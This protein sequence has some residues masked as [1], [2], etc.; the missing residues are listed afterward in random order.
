VVETMVG[1]GG[2][3]RMAERVDDV[4]ER[5]VSVGSKVD[6]LASTAEERFAE[7]AD[8]FVEQRRYTDFAYERLDA[9][10]TKLDVRMTT[11]EAQMR[12]GFARMDRKLDQLIDRP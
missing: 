7:V 8:A 9:S 3:S 4:L 12:S 2:R 11:F 6:L 10:I 1:S 5:L